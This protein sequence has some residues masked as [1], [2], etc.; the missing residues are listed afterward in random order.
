[1]LSSLVPVGREAS[2]TRVRD[3]GMAWKPGTLGAS[4]PEPSRQQRSHRPPTPAPIP[5]SRIR[6][7]GGRSQFGLSATPGLGAAALGVKLSEVCVPSW[8]KGKKW[9]LTFSPWFS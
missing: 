9:S 7:W 1:M 5:W 4:I 3:R 6:A 8:G 2:L